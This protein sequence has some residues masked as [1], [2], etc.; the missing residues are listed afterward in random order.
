ANALYVGPTAAATSDRS[1]AGATAAS[2]TTNVSVVAMSGAIIPAPL[3]APTSRTARRPSVTSRAATLGRLS[4]VMIASANR[5]NPSGASAAR[6]AAIP[7][8]TRSIASGRP[9]TPVD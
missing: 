3:V 8:S 2:V 9:I 6:A 4:V 1:A 7:R 5:T